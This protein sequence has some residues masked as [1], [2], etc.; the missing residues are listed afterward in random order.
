M[1]AVDEHRELDPGRPTEL[2]QR[3]QRGSDRAA[4]REDVVD[5]DDRS[6][7]EREVEGRAADERLR[8]RGR[9]AV[10]D[11]DVVAVEGDVERADVDLDA[12]ALGDETREPVRQWDAA[13]VDADQCDGGQIVS[14]LDQLVC[15]ARE[16]PV[17][18]L[19][20][21]QCRRRGPAGTFVLISLLSGLAG[22]GLGG[23]ASLPGSRDGAGAR[24]Q[25]C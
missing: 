3:V 18:G 1:T 8:A 10:A 5:Q 19:G 11:G 16:D 17:D 7:L 21:E 24:L 20:V 6:V 14:S 25:G 9:G 13:G 15:D 2:E 12:A 4:G 22:P 23:R